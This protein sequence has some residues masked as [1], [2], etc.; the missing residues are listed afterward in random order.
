MIL[1]ELVAQ[2][3]HCRWIPDTRQLPWLAEAERPNTGYW[4]QSPDSM[5]ILGSAFLT[6]VLFLSPVHV[7]TDVAIRSIPFFNACIKGVTRGS[8]RPIAAAAASHCYFKIDKKN[9]QDARALGLPPK[10]TNVPE[11]VCILKPKMRCL[12]ITQLKNELSIQCIWSQINIK[13]SGQ[14]RLKSDI[15]FCFR[16]KL[17]ILSSRFTEL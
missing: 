3:S 10:H 12:G 14:E 5:G 11:V 13:M 9:C 6:S 2:A 8:V 17:K 16:I 4:H 15:L 7:I 1:K